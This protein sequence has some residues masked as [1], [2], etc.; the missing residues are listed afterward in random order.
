VFNPLPPS[1]AVRKQKK[2]LKDLFS[3]LLSKFKKYHPSGNLKFNNLGIF[4]S[5]NFNGKNPSNF[6]SAKFHSKYYW[7]FCYGLIGC[8]NI[9]QRCHGNGEFLRRALHLASNSGATHK[10]SN[11]DSVYVNKSPHVVPLVRARQ[12]YC[13]LNV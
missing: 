9:I 10:A 4:H 3:S 7:L 12:P 11:P 1:D 5:L 8:R 2:K 13:T 6:S